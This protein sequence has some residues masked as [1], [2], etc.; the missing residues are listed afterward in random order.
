[1]AKNDGSQ[2]IDGTEDPTPRVSKPTM[3]YSAA[4]LG[5]RPSATN[6]ARLRPE[7]PGP[8]GL[9][10]RMP[11][12]LSGGAVAGTWDSASVIFLPPGWE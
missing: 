1:M 10:S 7:P 2:C 4:T 12:R 3:S 6:A 5:S 9:T 11:W 8:P